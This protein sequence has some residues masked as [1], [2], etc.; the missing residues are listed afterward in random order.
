MREYAASSFLSRWYGWMALLI[1]GLGLRTRVW[2]VPN[3]VEPL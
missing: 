3:I 2:V 1:A